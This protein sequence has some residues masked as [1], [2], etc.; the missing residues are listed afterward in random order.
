MTSPHHPPIAVLPDEV[1]LDAVRAQGAGGQNVN[2]VSTAIHLRFDVA[3]S[4]LP[5]EVKQ[6]LLHRRDQRLSKDGVF[7]LKAQRYRTQEA[8]RQDAMARLLA[9]VAEGAQVP[10][11]RKA[12]RPTR[13]SRQRRLEGK[14]QRSELKVRRSRVYL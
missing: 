10:V 6:R 2:K 9:W 14:L 3:A 11:L 4:S 8:N 7:V 12:T 1:Q 13:A 5:D